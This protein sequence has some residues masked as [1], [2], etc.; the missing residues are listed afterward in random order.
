MY[1][2][3]DG[4]DNSDPNCMLDESICS[5]CLGHTPINLHSPGE[6]GQRSCWQSSPTNCLTS[7]YLNDWTPG[8]ESQRLCWQSSP[9][10][11]ALQSVSLNNIPPQPSW[12]WL[13]NNTEY[14]QLQHLGACNYLLEINAH[15]WHFKQSVKGKV[16]SIVMPMLLSQQNPQAIM[17]RK[18]LQAAGAFSVHD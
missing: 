12:V 9:T 11:F 6:E 2:I 13:V 8:E 15:R 14:V 4:R 16:N 10:N 3:C 1:V 17:Q 7:A 5:S 18:M